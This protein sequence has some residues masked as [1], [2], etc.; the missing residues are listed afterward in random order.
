[1]ALEIGSIALQRNQ[2]MRQQTIICY[3]YA[4]TMLN[5]STTLGMS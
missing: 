4:A 2:R 1:M 5:L 3:Q